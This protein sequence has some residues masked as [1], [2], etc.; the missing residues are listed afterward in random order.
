MASD[1]LLT[2]DPFLAAIEAKVAAWRAV[3][4]SY[5]AA[6]ALDGPLN[7]A[8]AV[9]NPAV[10]R[11]DLPVGVFRSMGVKEAIVVYL[12]SRRQKQT[13]KEIAVGLQ[14]GGIHS[15][16][17]SFESTVATALYRLK[18]DGVVLRFPDGWD[19]ASSYPDSLRARMEKD[20][21]PA[22]RA[23]AR[24]AKRRPVAAGPKLLESPREKEIA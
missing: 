3:A 1:K 12:E 20:R 14:K 13:N 8:G 15:E 23:K 7:D 4:E 19:L 2:N 11:T 5:R 16:S 6:V 17:G 22:K 18:A 10:G 21:K 24:K 9:P